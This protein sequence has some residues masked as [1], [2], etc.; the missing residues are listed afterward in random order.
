[1]K[2]I[3]VWFVVS[4]AAA[5]S[6]P[7]QQISEELKPESIYE[8]TGMKGTSYEKMMEKIK[9][10][11]RI[12][13][14]DIPR[15][16][17]WS[18]EDPMYQLDKN[19]F[20]TAKSIYEQYPYS[21]NAVYNYGVLIYY[22]VQ[23]EI[24]L[25]ASEKQLDAAYAVFEQARKI[26][27]KEEGI[28]R[29]QIIILQQ[30][31]FNAAGGTQEPGGFAWDQYSRE[32]IANEQYHWLARAL[33]SRITELFKLYGVVKAD[34]NLQTE[35][36]LQ[37]SLLFDAWSAYEI[38]TA[39]H[40]TQS[41]AQWKELAQKWDNEYAQAVKEE[42]RRNKIQQRAFERNLKKT[43]LKTAYLEGL[44]QLQQNLK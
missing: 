27:P 18:L 20:Y 24:G 11:Q 35:S 4:I 5:I 3:L 10:R 29:H 13:I 9:N 33:L 43:F 25:V 17:N 19:V 8:V 21:F 28:Y 42:Q 36:A 34:G 2:K 37:P 22:Q 41:A 31:I 12:D 15:G 39:L 14:G 30:K 23:P 26:N 44:Q 1:M 32:V 7:A 16:Y 40:R 6:L 38:C